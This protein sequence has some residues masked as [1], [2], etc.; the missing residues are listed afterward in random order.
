MNMII[1]IWATSLCMVGIFFVLID[2]STRGFVSAFLA[3]RMS[4]GKKILITIKSLNDRYFR[5]GK[6]SEKNF[7]DYKDQDKKI[8]KITIPT[9]FQFEIAFG[10]RT[11]TFNE[12]ENTLEQHNK[13]TVIMDTQ[14]N[15]DLYERTLKA[16]TVKTNKDM[17]KKNIIPIIT[18]VG[19]IILLYLVYQIYQRQD[20]MWNLLT[21]SVDIIKTIQTK[22]VIN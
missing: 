4:K 20:L 14:K 15:E 8:Q 13:T 22:G 17:I 10:L 16:P 9:D 6:L 2:T 19:I 7:I 18:I 5:T 1:L 3:T 12:S 21:E 11:L